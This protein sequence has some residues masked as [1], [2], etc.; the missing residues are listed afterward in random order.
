VKSWGYSSSYNLTPP[1]NNTYTYAETH[2]GQQTCGWFDVVCNF[3][4]EEATQLFHFDAAGAVR[5][6]TIIVRTMQ[7]SYVSGM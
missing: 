7:Y 5:A 4:S 2:N 3:T 6:A 1:P